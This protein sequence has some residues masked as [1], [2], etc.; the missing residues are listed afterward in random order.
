MTLGYR[1]RFYLLALLLLVGISV[2]LFRL[3]VV[4]IDRYEEFAAKVPEAAEATP[5]QGNMK[6]AIGS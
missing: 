5:Q 4:Q 1:I 6:S 3:F 2:I